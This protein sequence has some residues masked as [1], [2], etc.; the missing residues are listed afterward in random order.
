[1][2][3]KIPEVRSW[4]VIQNLP[5]EFSLP[6]IQPFMAIPLTFY[7]WK[8]LH[9]IQ[10]WLDQAQDILLHFLRQIKRLVTQWIKLNH[11]V[12]MGPLEYLTLLVSYLTE[13]SR[14]RLKLCINN[15]LFLSEF[16]SFLIC[17]YY[18]LL[19]VRQSQTRTIPSKCWLQK[20]GKREKKI[21]KK[22]WD[23]INKWL[24]A[25]DRKKEK[26]N[27][28]TRHPKPWGGSRQGNKGDGEG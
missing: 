8:T 11:H 20:E 19:L 21:F 6:Q 28:S 23:N 4:D 17:F 22:D 13:I 10:W 27:F 15:F 2:L 3:L 26:M 14:I 12:T 1:M 25:L 24:I 9:H 5:F 7:Y 18:A 16:I